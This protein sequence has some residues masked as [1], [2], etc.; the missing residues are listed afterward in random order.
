MMQTSVPDMAAEVVDAQQPCHLHKTE[1]GKILTK[2]G[3]GLSRPHP[4]LAVGGKEEAV[5]SHSFL[6]FS[7][8]CISIAFLL[9]DKIP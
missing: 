9:L 2:I 1:P 7:F 8:L 4:L 3:E 6:L 5:E